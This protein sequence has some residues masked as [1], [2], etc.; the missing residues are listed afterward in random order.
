MINNFV[1]RHNIRKA[2]SIWLA[3][4]HVI[5]LFGLI[6]VAMYCSQIVKVKME[7]NSVFDDHDR[8]P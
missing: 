4:V 3:F 1:E 7:N 8:H 2:E 5:G 6:H